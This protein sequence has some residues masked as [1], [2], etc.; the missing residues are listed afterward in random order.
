MSKNLLAHSEEAAIDPNVGAGYRA[1][2]PNRA[3]RSGVD[4]IK[5]RS[6]LH[7][8]QGCNGVALSKSVEHGWKRNIAQAVSIVREKHF[9]ALHIRFNGFQALTDIGVG[10]GLCKSNRPVIHV[11]VGVLDAL[12]SLRPHKIVG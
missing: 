7:Q 3:L 5:T 6:R 2:L 12:T 4:D 10:T 1:N 11:A 9:F 8:Q